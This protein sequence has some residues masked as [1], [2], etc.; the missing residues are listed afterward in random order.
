MIMRNGA[1]GVFVGCAHGVSA[2]KHID[3][4][5]RHTYICIYIDM[6]T[7]RICSW[8]V[9]LTQHILPLHGRVPPAAVDAAQHTQHAFFP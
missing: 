3:D 2:S 1:G 6:V 4:V 8:S 5:D 7:T 9:L